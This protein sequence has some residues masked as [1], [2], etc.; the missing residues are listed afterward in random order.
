MWRLIH[1]PTS[2]T[3]SDIMMLVFSH[4]NI[5][6]KS[7]YYVNVCTPSSSISS[8][9]LSREGFPNSSKEQTPYEN[10]K[11][12]LLSKKISTPLRQPESMDEPFQKLPNEIEFNID[13]S[14]TVTI[15]DGDVVPCPETVE[16][17]LFLV[18]KARQRAATHP[19][20]SS[21]QISKNVDSNGFDT[22]NI[23]HA[24]K[25]A[26]SKINSLNMF[27]YHMHMVCPIICTWFVQSYAHGLS[28]HQ[29]YVI[30]FIIYHRMT[31]NVFSLT[32]ILLYGLSN[33]QIYVIYFISSG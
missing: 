17:A 8:A 9:S 11:A 10:I 20:F 31:L 4:S 2:A 28:N 29:I 3:I 12:T 33:H 27:F 32:H 13:K 5:N 30:Y 22:Y 1:H 25:I 18:S 15:E 6:N 7:R 23:Y 26:N 16:E 21:D 19:S 24:K 14:A